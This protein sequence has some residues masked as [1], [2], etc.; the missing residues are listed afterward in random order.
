MTIAYI[1]HYEALNAE[2]YF[3]HLGK[4]E[5]WPE[6]TNNEQKVT[7]EGESVLQT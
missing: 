7:L 6:N 3:L 5:G 4:M 2:G 1:N